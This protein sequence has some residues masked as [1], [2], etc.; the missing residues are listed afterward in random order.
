MKLDRPS[1]C[2]IRQRRIGRFARLAAVPL[3][4]LAFSTSVPADEPPANQAAPTSALGIAVL[5]DLTAA[6]GNVALHAVLAINENLIGADVAQVDDVLRSHLGLGEG[7]GLV[8][9]SLTDDCPAAKAGIRKYDV[10]ITI[11]GEEIANL[12]GFRQALQASVEK[13]IALGFIRSGKKQ[14]AEVTPHAAAA[15]VLSLPEET[16][17]Q[18]QPKYW[19]GLGLAGADDTL[20]S[21][22]SLPAGEGLVV[23][24]VENDSPAAKAGVM[25]ND[26]ILKLD[27]K[28]STTIEALTEQLQ[29]IA[30]KSVSLELLRRGKPATLTVTPEPRR[31]TGAATAWFTDANIV[32]ANGLA[33]P[34]FVNT[35]QGIGLAYTAAVAPVSPNVAKQLSD[36]DAQIKQLEAALAALRATIEA[37]PQAA[38]GGEEKK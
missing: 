3:T 35:D 25:A 24:G 22:L 2:G 30:D 21:Q 37:N 12:D 13:P 6:N 5:Q 16:L 15:A 19:L 34:Y 7:K 29:A 31:E 9:T 32:W 10:L 27:G 26:V 14:S 36:L 20:R 4:F 18:V 8:V 23:T 17:A 1:A 28:A 33:T 11:G 38:P